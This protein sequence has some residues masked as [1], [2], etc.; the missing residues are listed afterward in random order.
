MR[1]K[2]FYLWFLKIVKTP[3]NLNHPSI[4]ESVYKINKFENRKCMITLKNNQLYSHDLQA[5]SQ[6]FPSIADTYTNN[7]TM[8][9]TLLFQKKKKRKITVKLWRTNFIQ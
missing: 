4:V 8:E 3:S 1:S 7:G 5:P 2:Y 6:L 9:S